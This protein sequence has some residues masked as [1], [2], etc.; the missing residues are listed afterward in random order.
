MY[1]TIYIVHYIFHSKTFVNKIKHL[2]NDRFWSWWYRKSLLSFR[3]TDFF[4]YPHNIF[5]F[6]SKESNY[7]IH[8][9][10][11]KYFINIVKLI[12]WLTCQTIAIVLKYF[13]QYIRKYF[14]QYIRKHFFRWIT[15]IKNVFVIAAM[16]KL[17]SW[18]DSR[19]M[20]IL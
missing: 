12:L 8:Q 2:I 6:Q 15:E 11:K 17:M 5:L 10:I 1:A 3:Y 7:S 9:I 13:Q 4:F 18:K 14:Q 16:E 20:D 19:F